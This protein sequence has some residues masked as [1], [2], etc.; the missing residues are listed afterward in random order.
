M[1]ACHRLR[2]ESFSTPDGSSLTTVRKKTGYIQLEIEIDK[3]ESLVRRGEICVA[4]I[5]C[6]N[7][8]SKRCLWQ[9]CLE[10]CVNR[11]ECQFSGSSLQSDGLEAGKKNALI[12]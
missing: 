5:R 11:V 9:I 1:P 4:D 2:T 10:S 8:E 6:L 3:I 7:C 12:R